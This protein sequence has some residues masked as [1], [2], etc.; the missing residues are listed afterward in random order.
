MLNNCE[1]EE[2]EYVKFF[3]TINS[4]LNKKINECRQSD[5]SDKI[6]E[7]LIERKFFSSYCLI[8]YSLYNILSIMVDLFCVDSNLVNTLTILTLEFNFYI[9]FLTYIHF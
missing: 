6:E 1:K 5:I 3:P 4:I 9:L 7:S 8:K 2:T